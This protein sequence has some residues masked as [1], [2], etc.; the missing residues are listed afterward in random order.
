M[1]NYSFSCH[2]SPCAIIGYMAA[3]II[4][5]IYGIFALVPV[6][7]FKERNNEV[8]IILIVLSATGLIGV[9]GAV[10][11]IM[12]ECLIRLPCL[13]RDSCRRD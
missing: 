6:R 8:G 12:I 4:A 9:I 1:A 11:G 7:P 10:A 2:M 13:I 3:T 5:L